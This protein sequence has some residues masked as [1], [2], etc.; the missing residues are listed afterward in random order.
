LAACA[1]CSLDLGVRAWAG[2]QFGVYQAWRLTE[3]MATICALCS[4]SAPGGFKR[5]H[6]FRLWP[7][8]VS[9][10]PFSPVMAPWCWFS[11]LPMCELAPFQCSALAAWAACSLDLGV[12]AWAGGQFGVCQAWRFTEHMATIYAPCVVFLRLSLFLAGWAVGGVWLGGWVG[13]AQVRPAL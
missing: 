6:F 1:A 7:Y 4:I 8:P 10:V 5:L 13:G 12:G 3:H 11:L 9:G 2:G